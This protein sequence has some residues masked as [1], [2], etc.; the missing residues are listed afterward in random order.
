MTESPKEY[1]VALAF[2]ICTEADGMALLGR[3]QDFRVKASHW[4]Y[5]EMTFDRKGARYQVYAYARRWKGP[6][7]DLKELEHNEHPSE[8]EI[9]DLVAQ[10]YE[11][12]G[13]FPIRPDGH[14]EP[15]AWGDPLKE[16]DMLDESDDPKDFDWVAE[17]DDF[18][19]FDEFEETDLAFEAALAQPEPPDPPDDPFDDPFD[20]PAVEHPTGAT[21]SC[22][23]CGQPMIFKGVM[24]QGNV[25]TGEKSTPRG[26]WDCKPCQAIVSDD[27][28]DPEWGWQ[29]WER[30]GGKR[31]RY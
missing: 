29:Q 18:D 25:L 1:R 23:D 9:G 13:G 26:R 2:E 11:A 4:Q 14:S 24:L 5:R 22:P 17:E 15:M 10:Y 16:D 28:I 12:L 19:D 20:S 8:E 6:G 3:P 30:Q 21:M 31:E 7:K 27:R